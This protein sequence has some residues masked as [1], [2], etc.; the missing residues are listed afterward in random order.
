MARDCRLGSCNDSARAR[1]NLSL[2]ACTHVCD[3]MSDFSVSKQSRGCREALILPT[4]GGNVC[5]Y[6]HAPRTRRSSRLTEFS[7]ES[8]KCHV[9]KA[10]RKP[11]RKHA[12]TPC[13]G[14]MGC[15][16]NG[17]LCES[18]RDARKGKWTTTR[19]GG[20]VGRRTDGG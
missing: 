19:E 7:R 9:S 17:M 13:G 11:T 18:D 3:P 6:E 16:K 5:T 1:A 12:R 10:A 14:G 20:R 15:L 4:R 8:R 2:R